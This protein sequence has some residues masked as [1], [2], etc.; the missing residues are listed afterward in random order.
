[1]A[2]AG[3]FPTWPP[4]PATSTITANSFLPLSHSQSVPQ[5]RCGLGV[6]LLGEVTLPRSLYPGP[7]CHGQQPASMGHPAGHGRGGL[8]LI[9]GPSSPLGIP[10]ADRTVLRPQGGVSLCLGAAPQL[11]ERLGWVL[12]PTC[13]G[14]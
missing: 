5:V 10:Q 4:F 8:P 13:P 6:K 1:M 3:S 2:Q 9:Q 11:V 14:A 12:G 7:P